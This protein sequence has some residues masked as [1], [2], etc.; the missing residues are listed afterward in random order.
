MKRIFL[1][2]FLTAL[3]LAGCKGKGVSSGLD[4]DASLAYTPEDNKVE[5]MLL[6][7]QAFP[8]QIISNG[9]VSAR[10]K[11]KLSFK[12]SG[13]IS[14]LAVRNG[15]RVASGSVVARLDRPDLKL[16]VEQAQIALD[17]SV[18]DL[19][20]FLAGQGYPVSDTAAVPSDLMEIA[21]MRSGN[22]AAKNALDRAKYEASGTILRAPFS[23]LV[24]DL[25][26]KAYDNAPSDALCTLID[27]SAMDVSFQVLESDFGK[28][29]QG[30]PLRVQ[31]FSDPSREYGGT[32]TAINPS[33][34]KNSLVEVTGGLPGRIGLVD[35]MNVKVIIER[36]LPD[37]LVVPKSAV[38]I[39]DGLHVLFTYT[40]DGVAHWVYVNIIDSNSESYAVE[41]NADRGAVLAEGDQV[42]ITGN[43][44]LADGT[45]VSLK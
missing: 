32:V 26:V 1:I 39:R 44:N 36:T 3:L 20:D 29:T 43:L 38:V 23:G 7:R 42:I 27:D 15:S 17:R 21:R 9:K 25:K 4:N 18:I 19:Q 33:V 14:Y 35:G 30:M 13:T 24:A 6:E 40:D 8:V 12:T 11:A 22:K 28:V 16:A 31:S 10:R 37:M 2:S 45:K 41:A 34:G 5:I